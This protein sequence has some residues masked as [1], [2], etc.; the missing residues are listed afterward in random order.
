MQYYGE[1]YLLTGR[2]ALNQKNEEI[3]NKTSVLGKM[4]EDS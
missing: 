1:C 4:V 3:K 2:N